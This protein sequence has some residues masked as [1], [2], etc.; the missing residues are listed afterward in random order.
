[1]DSRLR[2][3]IDEQRKLGG[4]VSNQARLDREFVRLDTTPTERANVLATIRYP[5]WLQRGSITYKEVLEAFKD[6]AEAKSIFIQ[7]DINPIK[8][9]YSDLRKWK[10]RSTLDQIR[11]V[12]LDRELFQGEIIIGN[13]EVDDEENSFL[14]PIKLPNLHTVDLSLLGSLLEVSREFPAI[15]Y[16]FPFQGKKRTMIL[17]V[18]TEGDTI[19]HALEL[20]GL[21]EMKSPEWEFF[22]D[23]VTLNYLDDKTAGILAEKIN[24]RNLVI[25][26]CCNISDTGLAALGRIQKLRSINIEAN[27]KITDIGLE[28]LIRSSNLEEILLHDSKI[29]GVAFKNSKKGSH[30]IKRLH[31]PSGITNDGLRAIV[32]NCP[33]LTEL[34]MSYSNITSEAFSLLTKIK[35]LKELIVI[36]CDGLDDR[37]IKTISGIQ[38]LKSIHLCGV[39]ITD[40]DLRNLANLENLTYLNLE[41]CEGMTR[42]GLEWFKK[43]LPQC[44]IIDESIIFE[45]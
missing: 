21:T 43:K 27:S 38:T 8:Y 20:F 44:E 14:I 30:G 11:A 10:N 33:E 29:S 13:E 12:I 37:A 6:D 24:C 2:K 26:T 18:L 3:I 4:D 25:Y 1:M 42:V 36:N 35:E 17:P 7:Q 32:E 39:I 16:L 40:E 23:K 34:N 15:N 41:N 5:E 9:T 19:D 31:F 28:N 45:D 22:V